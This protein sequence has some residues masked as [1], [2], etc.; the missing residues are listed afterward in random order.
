MMLFDYF[1]KEEKHGRMKTTCETV[2]NSFK[3]LIFWMFDGW[4][5]LDEI[6]DSMGEGSTC[7]DETKGCMADRQP[8]VDGIMRQRARKFRR[9]YP[10]VSV[11][12]RPSG[13]GTE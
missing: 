13:S 12:E 7:E 10:E 4:I 11:S 2:K 8:A 3:R 6:R 9:Q 5:P 1:N